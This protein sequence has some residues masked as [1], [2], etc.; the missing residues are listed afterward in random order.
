[1]SFKMDRVH[2]WSVEVPDNS[3]KIVEILGKLDDANA[4]LEYVETEKCPDN[5]GCSLLC[6]APIVG[7]EQME[8]AREAGLHE[9]Q[10]PV[11]MRVVGDDTAGLAHRI[12]H[13]WT[14]AGIHLHSAM[15]TSIGDKFVGYITFDTVDDGNRAA[16]IL[17]EV[18]I[19]QPA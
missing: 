16:I 6:V 7:A 1:M 2:I 19:Q 14:Q 10:N 11:V 8:A 4:D 17:A 15:M 13:A 12:K 3:N 18:G 5:P 9:V